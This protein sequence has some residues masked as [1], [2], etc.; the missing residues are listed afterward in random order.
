MST[1]ITLDVA[2]GPAE[3]D[4]IA[5]AAGVVSTD[6]GAAA[7]HAEHVAIVRELV[8][9]VPGRFF[10]RELPCL[11]AVMALVAHPPAI[12]VIDGYVWLDGGGRRGLGAELYHALDRT[13]AVVGVAKAPFVGAAAVEVRRGE[14]QRPLFV[15]AAGIDPRAAA[16]K[17]RAMHGAYRLPTLIKR[18]DAL[19]RKA[20][21]GALRGR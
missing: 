12:V 18:A 11:L 20:L 7:P 13:A 17:V 2:Y 8:P 5:A 21:S 9:Y 19:G 3:E 6:W 16:E 15:T 14:S 1:L 4:D 10:E